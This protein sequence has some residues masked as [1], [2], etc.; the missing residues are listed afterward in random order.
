MHYWD[1]M[2]VRGLPWHL[3]PLFVLVSPRVADS[4]IEP[5]SN[6]RDKLLDTLLCNLCVIGELVQ[7]ALPSSSLQ[8][9]LET[10]KIN[11]GPSNFDKFLAIKRLPLLY[12]PD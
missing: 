3:T 7:R 8:K 10:E 4:E 6:L 11:L 9:L 2:E 5:A 1:V 12:P